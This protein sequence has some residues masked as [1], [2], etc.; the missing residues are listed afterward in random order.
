MILT[1]PNCA[2][3]Y[4][5]PPDAL[6]P[7]GRQLKCS[8]CAEVWQHELPPSALPTFR[9]IAP[10]PEPIATETPAEP[11]QIPQAQGLQPPSTLVPLFISRAAKP[12]VVKVRGGALGVG[13]GLTVLV[14]VIIGSVVFRAEII[15]NWPLTTK[16]Y[17]AVG[18][19]P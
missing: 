13:I 14:A 9:F 18:L 16:V 19:Y 6:V 11:L 8:E 3:R 7:A 4:F 15:S 5:A 1:C 17:A 2:T 10:T 12:K